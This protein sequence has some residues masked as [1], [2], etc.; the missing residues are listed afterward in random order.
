MMHPT[1]FCQGKQDIDDHPCWV[2][3]SMMLLLLTE[4]DCSVMGVMSTK[5]TMVPEG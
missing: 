3:A 1:T 4:I 2:V 5:Q